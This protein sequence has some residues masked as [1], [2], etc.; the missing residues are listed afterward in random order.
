MKIKKILLIY[1]LVVSIVLIG[2]VYGAQGWKIVPNNGNY[3]IK[4]T[5]GDKVFLDKINDFL[6]AWLGEDKTISIN[7]DIDS[8]IEEIRNDFMDKIDFKRS[9]VINTINETKEKES[10]TVLVT[11]NSGEALP[12]VNIYIG[13]FGRYGNYT[14]NE[15]GIAIVTAPNVTSDQKIV[16]YAEKLFYVPAFKTIN[17]LDVD[18]V[19][20]LDVKSEIKAGEEF[21]VIVRDGKDEPVKN[22]TVKF[23]GETSY[24][25]ENGVAKFKAPKITNDRFYE[26]NA[27]KEG[28]KGADA[29]I[30]VIGEETGFAS[31]ILGNWILISTIIAVICVAIFAVWWYKQFY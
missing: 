15:S 2:L 10:F 13:L 31:M 21:S 5:D 8:K 28:Y 27:E 9:L 18:T 11:D 23:N 30:T 24:T 4:F 16:I 17:V 19:L 14:T 3:D 26:I 25:D 29:K 7:D 12:D 1:A 22:A 20:T 6:R